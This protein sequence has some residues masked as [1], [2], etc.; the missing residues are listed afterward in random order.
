MSSKQAYQATMIQKD[1]A[2]EAA[3]QWFFTSALVTN[4]GVTYWPGK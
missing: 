3:S 1:A 4:S 2:S